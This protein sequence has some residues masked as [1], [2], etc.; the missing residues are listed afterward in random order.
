MSSACGTVAQP[1]MA[2]MHRL[3]R[4]V[5]CMRYRRATG[6]GRH[7]SA[8]ALASGMCRGRCIR[9]STPNTLFSTHL[10]RRP[11][12]WTECWCGRCCRAVPSGWSTRRMQMLATPSS[13]AAP[14]G[15][16]CPRWATYISLLS[17]VAKRLIAARPLFCCVRKVH[18]AG[19]QPVVAAFAV[20]K[21]LALQVEAAATPFTPAPE[22]C[23]SWPCDRVAMQT[24]LLR[25]QRPFA[26]R[27]VL[28]PPQGCTCGVDD[29]WFGTSWDGMHAMPI[30]DETYPVSRKA[31]IHW[32]A[33]P[34]APCRSSPR[35]LGA[36]RWLC[37]L[38]P[39]VCSS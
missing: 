35:Y 34:E 33:A 6:N 38:R 25:Y 13:C 3:R 5:E 19:A 32:C 28:P 18:F 1:A 14:A 7:A 4:H 36:A 12:C 26:H 20:R 21:V 27:S 37:V 11:S 16:M 15:A 9:K 17:G 39:H 24:S 23:I 30:V 29:H 31:C 10:P 22:H 8:V 2:A